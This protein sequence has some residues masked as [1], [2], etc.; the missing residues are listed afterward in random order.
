[1]P[2]L[3][4]FSRWTERRIFPAW[5]CRR[6]E[7]RAN[8][9]LE[10]GPLA[11]V[12]HCPREV[13]LVVGVDRRIA[14]LLRRAQWFRNQNQT[15]VWGVGYPPWLPCHRGCTGRPHVSPLQKAKLGR[16]GPYRGEADTATQPE[17]QACV[18]CK[19]QSGVSF[20]S[21]LPS[22]DRNAREIRPDLVLTVPRS[23][24]SM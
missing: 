4:T 2:S 24:C 23:G 12:P 10:T 21:S 1:M 13:V 15:R 5:L 19:L 16:Y 6:N 20:G 18:W 3:G 11:Q 8:M 9:R 14:S 22:D 17:L 7:A